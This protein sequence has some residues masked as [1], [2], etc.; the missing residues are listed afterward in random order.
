MHIIQL[1]WQ[2]VIL[3][4]KISQDQFLFANVNAELHDAE[5]ALGLCIFLQKDVITARL[6]S[7]IVPKPPGSSARKP[8]NVPLPFGSSVLA[9]SK[10]FHAYLEICM[11]TMLSNSL[12]K[13]I[14]VQSKL[15]SHVFLMWQS[16]VIVQIRRGSFGTI[17]GCQYHYW[18]QSLSKSPKSLQNLPNVSEFRKN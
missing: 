1:L 3:F 6:F 2:E 5:Q 4:H 18:Q 16:R 11:Q 8:K 12:K 9:V 10:V 15:I 7:K 17:I 14:A 13:A